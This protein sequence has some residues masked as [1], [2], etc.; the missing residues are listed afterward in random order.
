MR[1][2][3]SNHSFVTITLQLVGKS[4]AT[5]E[6]KISAHVRDVAVLLLRRTC[7]GVTN[8]TTIVGLT[9]TG[10]V[11]VVAVPTAAVTANVR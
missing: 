7:Q 6:K 8:K 10:L 11:V 2:S 1:H 4:Y 9:A 5:S 3:H